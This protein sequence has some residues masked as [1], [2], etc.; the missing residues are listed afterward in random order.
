MTVISPGFELGVACGAGSYRGKIRI[1]V[2]RRKSIEQVNK[3]AY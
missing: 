2:A 3:A 1:A